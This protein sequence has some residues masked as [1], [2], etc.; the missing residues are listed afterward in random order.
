MRSEK[1]SGNRVNMVPMVSRRESNIQTDIEQLEKLKT[2]T[3]TLK[4]MLDQKTR[5]LQEATEAIA[6]LKHKASHFSFL[7]TTACFLVPIHLAPCYFPKMEA[8]ALGVG[9]ESA[10]TGRRCQD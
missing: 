6:S 1:E 10:E 5:Q 9:D 4:E 2:E 8:L 7:I 3:V